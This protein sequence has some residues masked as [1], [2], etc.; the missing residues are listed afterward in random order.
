MQI[1]ACCK[2][3]VSSHSMHTASSFKDIYESYNTMVYNLALNYVQ[4]QEDAEDITQEVFV[5]L[6]LHKYDAASA[7]LKTWIYR[8]T[9]N[10][11]LD[12]VKATQTKKRFGFIISL[13]SKESNEPVAEAI[14]FNHPGIIAEDREALKRLFAIINQLPHNQKTALLLTRMD[15]RPQ[16]EVAEIMNMNIKAVESLLQRAKQT[17]A[18][19]WDAGE[20]KQ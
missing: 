17:I 20:G 8:I 11:C 13:F 16:K 5:K 3:F 14:H 4:Q 10:Q 7:S 1:S 15:E 2:K 19:K 9:I 12:F 6:H 18:K